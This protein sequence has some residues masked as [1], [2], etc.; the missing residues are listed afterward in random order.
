M[1]CEEDGDVDKSETKLLAR[2]P[3]IHQVSGFIASAPGHVLRNHDSLF[4]IKRAISVK[5][6]GLV[7]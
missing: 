7:L 4:T 5:L 6:H 1:K 2:G 3:R